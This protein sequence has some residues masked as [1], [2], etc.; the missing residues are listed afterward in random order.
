MAKILIVDDDNDIII[1]LGTLLRDNGFDVIE[2]LNGKEGFE[3]AQSEKPDLICL[4]IS[5]PEES[6]VKAY[7]NLTENEV[8][9]DIPIFIV[10]GVAHD[11]KNF[12]ETRKQ[13]PP[14]VAYFDKPIDKDDFISKI[15]SVLKIK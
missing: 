3:K 14:P 15:K 4:D 12:I 6:G 8:T 2:A 1:Y 7:R 9:K 10:T 5:M 11:F 13:V